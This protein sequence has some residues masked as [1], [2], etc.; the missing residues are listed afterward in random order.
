M[1]AAFLTL[2]GCMAPAGRVDV[3]RYHLPDTAALGHGTIAVIAGPGMDPQSPALQS[4]E[5]AV[6]HELARLGYGILR[7]DAADQIAQIRIQR[8][9]IEQP[10]T[11]APRLGFSAAGGTHGSA[12]GVGLALPL[13]GDPQ[14]ATDLAVVIRDRASGKVLWEGRSS[15]TAAA[16]SPQAQTPLAAPR[17]ASALFSDFPGNS[18]ETTVP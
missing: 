9:A 7:A 12:A 16:L 5:V 8:S 10:G 11:I 13:S 2:A 17:L 6:E 1:A 15:F 14:V 4:H 18:G 3:V